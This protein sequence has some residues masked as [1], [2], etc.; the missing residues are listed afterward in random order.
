M[1]TVNRNRPLRN[2]VVGPAGYGSAPKFAYAELGLAGALALNETI[3]AIRL[4]AGATV[5]GAAMRSTDMDT[6][7]SPAL[8]LALGDSVDDD[9]LMTGLTIGQ[10][11]T[12]SS[13]LAVTGALY[14]YAAATTIQLKATTAAA[15]WADGTVTVCVQ[16]IIT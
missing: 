4:P 9:R 11:G 6:G 12:A 5:I 8:V 13:A 1:T 3:D 15:T 7:G 2:S 14:R 10:T 16:Y